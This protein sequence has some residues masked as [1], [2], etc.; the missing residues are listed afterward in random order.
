M[1]ISNSK[2]SLMDFLLFLVA[3][4]WGLNYVIV[5]IS[6][7]EM[8]PLFFNAVRFVVG[9]VTCWTVLLIKE[10]NR[11]VTREE[12]KKLLVLG[13]GAHAFNQL[14]FVHGVARTTAAATSI[15]LATTPVWVFLLAYLLKL[16]KL[17]TKILVGIFFSF[18]G[19]ILVV[20]NFG[21]SVV[22]SRNVLNGNI[23]ILIATLFWSLYTVL[24]KAFFKDLSAAKLTAYSL[25]IT[26]TFFVIIS[27]R[28]ALATPW[29]QYSLQAWL[30]A[31]YSGAFV[32]G[33]SYVLWN[34]AIK[35]VGP[36]R[37]AVYAN[38]PPFVS[39]LFGWILLG[40]KIG[41][42]QIFGG[43]FILL[44]LNIVNREKAGLAALAGGKPAEVTDAVI[45]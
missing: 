12:I 7:R 44:G 13:L 11:R 22:F 24:V 34:N 9:A 42:I 26:A 29:S 32:F 3:V 35:V 1:K 27:S 40:E 21:T 16:E 38:L 41:A 23:L 31:F 25:S 37:T 4:I 30:G 6:L 5:K 18:V 17:S 43:F 10:K 36:T 15:I 28:A 8:D 39:T 20:M 2:L 19:T 45:Q 14:A 33:I